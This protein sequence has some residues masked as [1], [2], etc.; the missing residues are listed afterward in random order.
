ML[1]FITTLH[2][3]IQMVLYLRR[4]DIKMRYKIMR[5]YSEI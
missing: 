5:I 1:L 4:I 2:N 3:K